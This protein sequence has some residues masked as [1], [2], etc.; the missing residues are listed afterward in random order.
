MKKGDFIMRK[1]FGKNG[2]RIIC[3]VIAVAM[4][5]PIVISAVLTVIG[6]SA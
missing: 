4:V 3:L 5:L 6:A 2:M 1:I